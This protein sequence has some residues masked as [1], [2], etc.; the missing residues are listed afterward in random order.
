M[1]LLYN[2]QNQFHGG[3]IKLRSGSLSLRYGVQ[4]KNSMLE[5]CKP[6]Q[7]RFYVEKRQQQFKQACEVLN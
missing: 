1:R 3:S 4:A 2:I 5:I 7:G 6:C